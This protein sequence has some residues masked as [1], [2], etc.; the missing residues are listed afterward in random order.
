MNK[1]PT[2]APTIVAIRFTCS[3][4]IRWR[5]SNNA[6]RMLSIKQ[7][8]VPEMIETTI[9]DMGFKMIPNKN[10]AIPIMAAPR[11]PTLV[12]RADTAPFVPGSTFWKVVI[13]RG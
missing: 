1:I 5:F 8:T 3:F 12:P 2:I 6:P 9:A 4:V 13:K 11:I 10:A 7:P